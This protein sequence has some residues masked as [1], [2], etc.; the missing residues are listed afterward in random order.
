MTVEEKW[1]EFAK[2]CIPH[3]WYPSPA[4]EIKKG[5][6]VGAYIMFNL[7]GEIMIDESIS[8]EEATNRVNA[9]REECLRFFK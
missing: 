7:F 3:N 9:L 8:N 5:F 2:D 6:Y 4:H 1:K